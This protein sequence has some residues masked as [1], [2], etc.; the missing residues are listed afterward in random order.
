[1]PGIVPDERVTEGVAAIVERLSGRV[2]EIA[3]AM[4]AR[5]RDEIAEYSTL[6]DDVLEDDVKRISVLNMRA[7]LAN[8]H[9]GEVLA[10]DELSESRAGAARRVH[11]GIS[12]ESL[13]HAYRLWG[14]SVW[15]AILETAR[16][17]SPEERE[18]ALMIAGRVIAHIDHVSHTAAQAY[19]DEAQSLLSER[20]V[21]RRD[22]L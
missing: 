3:G 5:Y 6:D 7:L 8:L 19:L 20:E 18:A 11:H 10:P 17:D 16:V 14:Q 4:I 21:V 15:E 22:L 13:L 2:E 9:R 12:L 1:M